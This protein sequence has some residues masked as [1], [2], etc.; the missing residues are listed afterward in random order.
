LIL[1]KTN[2]KQTTH[3]QI[4][5]NM[6]NLCGTTNT[7]KANA[8][9]DVV[10]NSATNLSYLGEAAYEILRTKHKS[11]HKSEWNVTQSQVVGPLQHTPGP[12][13]FTSKS[14]PKDG[15]SDWFAEKMCELMSSTTKW[16]DVMS[17]GSPDGLFLEQF[18][19]ALKNL[20]ESNK[21]ASASGADPIVIRFMFGNII[22]VPINCERVLKKLTKGLPEDANLRIWVGAWRYAATWNH[23]KLIAVDGKHLQTGGH[24]VWSDIYLKDK[25]VHDVSIQLVGNVAIDGH[26]FADVQWKF[27]EKKQGTII[28]QVL[29]NV[30]DFL[31]LV[32]KSRVIVSEY[33]K[34]KATEFPPYY[35]NSTM[36]ASSET[37]G[38]QDSK[39]VPVISVGR[40]GALVKD[41]RPADDAFIAM[42]D[43]SKKIIRMSLQDLGPIC[44]PGLKVPLPSVGWPKPYLDALARAIW[45]RGVDVQIVLTNENARSGYTNG[46]DC[47]DVGSEII[48]RIQKQF[49][50][51]SDAALRQ[52][53]DDNLFIC[54]I[55]HAGSDTYEN[56][57][58]RIGNHT[59]W[60]IVDDLISYTGSQN[61]YECDLAEWGVLVDDAGA[62]GDMVSYYWNPM[63]E[64]S[65]MESD[66]E[67][68]DVM[69]G[70]KIDRDG[71]ETNLS[72]DDL[73]NKSEAAM[74]TIAMSQMPSDAMDDYDKEE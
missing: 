37:D 63:W 39:L 72:G 54:F 11:Y 31:P 36:P 4:T 7:L 58:V 18:Q 61:L 73:I 33:P 34:G 24:N 13:A 47:K 62:T 21:A 46:W 5:N 23:A 43:A 57:K 2:N 65:F 59:K 35:D 22:G 19:K 6:G 12:S 27:I 32:A 16:C 69:D 68:Q 38:S 15:H 26:N 41:D 28:G 55:R 51:A 50:D 14:D 45:L 52:K 56:S 40:Q 10:D 60:F 70:L 48:K 3:K 9:E 71:E 17:L 49:P 8:A 25:P 20:A 42:I 53:V 1:C 64:A 67:V 30:P 74:S 44:L 29:E 66:C